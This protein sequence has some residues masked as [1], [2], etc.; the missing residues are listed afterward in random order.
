AVSL[1]SQRRT[2][3]ADTL[4][5]EAALAA[6]NAEEEAMADELMDRIGTGR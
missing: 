5:R 3:L 2:K 1:R 4:R 6:M